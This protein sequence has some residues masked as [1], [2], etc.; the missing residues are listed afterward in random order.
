MISETLKKP[1]ACWR[2]KERYNGT[3]VECL[4]I[5]F[6]SGGCSWARCRMC[7]YRFEKFP[8]RSCEG[9]AR[10]LHAQLSWVR[11]Q[12][13]LDEVAMIKVF[14][15]GS[16]FDP[17]E[18]PPA[19]LAEAAAAFRGKIVITETRPEYI[20]RETLERF[21]AEIDNGT[22]ATPLYCAIGLETSSDPIREKCINKG[23][24]FA[25]FT[26]AAHTA[27]AAGAG[28][29]AYLLFKPL[30]L[31]EAEA[32]ADMRSSFADLTGRVEMV[33]MNPCTVQKRTELE[34][35][36][37]QGAYRPPYLWSVLSLLKDAPME[38]TCDP[39]GGGQKRGPHNCGTCDYEIVRGIRDYSLTAD[40][41]L[42]G[43]L[44]D[45][46]CACKAEWEYV[47]AREQ[48][49]CMPLTR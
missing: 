5:I 42:I 37:R 12:F 14:T 19:F 43:A 21:V 46:E 20:N 32:V 18:V 22:H 47:L 45:T 40:R 3:T 10:H 4:T 23:F 49:Y 44:L 35:Y 48:P 33:S 17:A 30:F 15:S 16:F 41:D 29:K 9:L 6:E 39:L 31:T 38:V 13:S 7:S 8:D 11:S 24:S 25:D 34:L 2:G 28:V 36:W 27:H 1:L 26:A